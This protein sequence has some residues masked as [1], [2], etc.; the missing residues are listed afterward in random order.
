MNYLCKVFYNIGMDN[1]DHIVIS[2]T[3]NL[4]NSPNSA[5]CKDLLYL[6]RIFQ[7]IKEVYPLFDISCMYYIVKLI[8]IRCNIF[9]HDTKCDENQV[10]ISHFGTP[11]RKC[12]VT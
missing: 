8:K 3:F 7:F 11:L 4:K 12:E 6:L 1:T 5:L 10:P 9:G 2:T